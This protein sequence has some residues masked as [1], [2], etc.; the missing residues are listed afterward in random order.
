M[1]PQA[2]SSN[3]RLV[4][5]TVACRIVWIRAVARRLRTKTTLREAETQIKDRNPEEKPR[6]LDGN[7]A[8]AAQ[9]IQA[10]QHQRHQHPV[11]IEQTEHSPV[12]RD[13]GAA[14]AVEWAVQKG[15]VP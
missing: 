14:A 1:P 4:R 15:H 12:E 9:G 3:I 7:P 10:E 5:S 8:R 2:C 13:L 11:Q 6:R